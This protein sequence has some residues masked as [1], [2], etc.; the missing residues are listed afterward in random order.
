M[1]TNRSS[2]TTIRIHIASDTILYAPLY[3]FVQNNSRDTYSPYNFQIIPVHSGI[4]LDTEG[5]SRHDLQ[6]FLP[7]KDDPVFSKVIIKEEFDDNRFDWIG[8]GDPLRVRRLVQYHQAN[9]ISCEFAATLI[10]K[11]AFWVVTEKRCNLDSFWNFNYIGCHPLGMTGYYLSESLFVNGYNNPL[12][13]SR[14]PGQ[15]ID[16]VIRHIKYDRKRRNGASDDP[17]WFAAV[18][19]E[20][21]KMLFSTKHD[22][23]PKDWKIKTIQEVFPDFVPNDYLLTAIVARK[24]QGKLGD[25][26]RSATGFL[27]KGIANDIRRLQ[28]ADNVI[29]E[30]FLD[31]LVDFYWSHGSYRVPGGGTLYNLR[32]NLRQVLRR[33][34]DVYTPTLSA[35]FKAKQETDSFLRFAI[36]SDL[37]RKGHAGKELEVKLAYY[38]ERL[39]TDTWNAN[40][41]WQRP[42]V[43]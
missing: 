21:D 5:E 10:D 15:E 14:V 35:P 9:N 22:R 6:A 20:I 31:D 8:I 19:T 12:A 17:V 37:R 13:P 29:E 43:I 36:R 26:I 24:E 27:V 41:L 3:T 38:Y 30:D 39:N 11:M 32:K 42:E 7:I 34:R 28:I 40:T 16:Q 23:Y 33:I 2:K 25:D 1:F 4:S 18:S